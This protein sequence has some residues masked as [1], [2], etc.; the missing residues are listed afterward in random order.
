MERFELE[1]QLELIIKK[2]Q[3]ILKGLAECTIKCHTDSEH[4]NLVNA[5]INQ[6]KV[7]KACKRLLN[8]IRRP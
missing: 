5:E 1:N 3:E 8:N 2:S 6:E 7:E 4:V